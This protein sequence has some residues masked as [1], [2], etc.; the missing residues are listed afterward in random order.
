MY[1]SYLLLVKSCKSFSS[2]CISNSTKKLIPK[3]E[4]WKHM[5]RW[6][7][8]WRTAHAL[9]WRTPRNQPPL[10]HITVIT[11]THTHNP[12]NKNNIHHR[13]HGPPKPPA[14]D[15]SNV[16]GECNCRGWCDWSWSSQHGDVL[17][18]DDT[19]FSFIYLTIILCAAAQRAHW[20]KCE[21]SKI[22]LDIFLAPA[23][24][25]RT[26]T[27][28]IQW[29]LIWWCHRRTHLVSAW[30]WTGG[31]RH[32]HV[33]FSKVEVCSVVVSIPKSQERLQMVWIV[34]VSHMKIV[35]N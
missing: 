26:L 34:L 31:G 10:K 16:T 7:Y 28:S 23:S 18:I 3:T 1:V 20:L 19:N 35:R 24:K 9:A 11:H 25:Q 5:V 12:Q 29:Y 21:F 2:D 8:L 30:F 27:P 15:G 17:F 33:V 4:G 6:K 14:S 13:H 22:Y 32:C